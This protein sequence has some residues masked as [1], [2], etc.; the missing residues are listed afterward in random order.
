MT[1][2]PTARGVLENVGGGLQTDVPIAI[3]FRRAFL[4]TERLDRVEYVAVHCQ[5]EMG[6][7]GGS[8]P[9]GRGLV[10][11]ARFGRLRSS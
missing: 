7:A 6:L 10:A 5:A 2:T 3:E 4:G 9:T 8:C 11:R 1:A